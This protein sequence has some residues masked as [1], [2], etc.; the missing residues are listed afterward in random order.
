MALSFAFFAVNAA[1]L[2]LL[3]PTEIVAALAN[4][5]NTA[6][7]VSFARNLL[8]Y[9]LE[10][11]YG[12]MTHLV[13]VSPGPL[14]HGDPFG[15]YPDHPPVIVWSAALLMA[16]LGTDVL[17]GRLVGIAASAGIV[18]VLVA[19][20][21]RR[22]GA[23]PAL[24]TGATVMLMPVFYLHALPL[25]FEPL[26]CFAIVVAVLLFARYIDDGKTASFALAM[27][28]WIAGMLVDW[29]AYFLGLPFF[30]VLA[31]QGLRRRLAL[32]CAL[33]PTMYILTIGGYGL[34]I[35]NLRM[36]FHFFTSA[37]APHYDP[38]RYAFDTSWGYVLKHV[39]AFAYRN[40]G[41]PVIALGGLGALW[42]LLDPRFGAGLRFMI[43]AL[44]AVGVLNIAVFKLWAAEHSFWSYYLLPVLALGVAALC[45]A[46]WPPGVRALLTGARRPLAISLVVLAWV[47]LLRVPL[48]EI[49]AQGLPPRSAS[50]DRHIAELQEAA[51]D[52]G[53][54]YTD[55][56][57]TLLGRGYVIR[58]YLDRSLTRPARPA[59]EAQCGRPADMV[60]IAQ[61]A[62]EKVPTDLRTAFRAVPIGGAS[63]ATLGTLASAGPQGCP[64]VLA[65][66]SE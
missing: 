21:Y 45:A 53:A 17:A 64:R 51:K 33:P 20:A 15:I 37:M 54:I 52:A 56:N 58:W 10:V 9:P 59:V 25:N 29:P 6:Y 19:S 34:A 28:A 36:P 24:A 42:A 26:T 65:A 38:A 27:V 60:L 44:A 22:L 11:T 7:Y 43:A 39:A 8:R 3:A 48:R 12:S 1:V 46:P 30:V 13:G 66:L 18:A 14:I 55:G 2:Y 31:R 23:L 35:D 63:W 4:D 57:H 41:L 40:F 47:A 32:I 61:T 49:K 5:V 62:M 16:L 50:V